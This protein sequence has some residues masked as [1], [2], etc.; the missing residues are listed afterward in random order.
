M[1][2]FRMKI[3]TILITGASRGIGK[4]IALRFA[5]EG[6]HVYI[7]ANKSLEALEEVKTLIHTKYNAGCTIVPGDVGNP[8]DVQTFGISN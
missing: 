1:E 4:A 2:I 6:Y 5:A 3:K 7:N 8:F